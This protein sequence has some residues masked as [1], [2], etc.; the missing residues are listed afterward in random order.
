M[1]SKHNKEDRIMIDSKDILT[2][3]SIPCEEVSDV[4]I[5]SDTSELSFV[6]IELKDNRSSC[7]F[8]FQNNVVIKDYYKVKIKN[9]IIRKH[10]LY[11][12]IRMRRYKCKC[13]NKTFK[14]NFNFYDN[15]QCISKHTKQLVQSMLM[16]RIS[17]EYIA[18]ELDIN[19]KTVINI[20]DSM[21]EPQRLKLPNVIC[22]DEFHFSNANHKA[23]KYPCVIS[24]PFNTELIDIVESR[25]KD[26]LIDY[27]QH[28]SFKERNN[29][30]Y[31]ISDMNETY[32]SIYKIFFKDAIHI[33]DHFHIIKLFTEA[34][35]KIRIKIMKSYTS[36]SKEY[37][38]LKKNWKLFLMK[39]FDLK[40]NKF[41]NHRTGVVHYTLD[42]IDMVLKVYHD[43]YDV[44]WAKE[45]FSSSM[46]KLHNYDETKK[47]ID[48]FINKFSKS[49]NKELN[50]IGNTFKNWY[51]EI[52][53]SYSKNTYGVV[54]TNAMA[55]SN[56]NYIQT[57]INIGYGYTNFYRLRKRILYMSSNKNRNQKY[58]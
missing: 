19:K 21:P 38:Y 49:L 46:L 3:L 45:E 54:L 20:L 35:Q 48:F 31:F 22:L 26:Y 36:D 2:L 33:V 24:N 39:R 37:K 11:V 44:Y 23:G 1:V 6:D 12:E 53:N 7:P 51:K 27:F 9:S 47:R 17:M 15:N 16:D 29:V 57:L 52:I 41:I 25:R 10:K 55:E 42:S 18:K 14:Q 32:R 13:C 58:L 43:L 40:D 34:I 28:I 5:I 30:K 8:C 56:N 4:E 50:D